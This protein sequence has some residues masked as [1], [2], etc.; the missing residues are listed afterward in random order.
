MHPFKLEFREEQE[1]H[2]SS[3]G[4]RA[5]QVRCDALFTYIFMLVSSALA[6]LG[7]PDAA[8]SRNLSP[9]FPAAYYA[10]QGNK[11]F[12]TLDSYASRASKPN[13][14]T[15]VIRWEWPPWLYLTGH[16]DHWMTMDRLLVLYPTRVLNRDCRSFKVQPFS[17][18]RVTFHYE[19]IDS[20]V[21]IYQEFTFNDYGQITFIEAWTDEPGFLPMNATIDRWAEGK[22]VSRLSTRVP[23]LGRADGR[24]QAIPPQHL[25]R[26]DRD[27]RN[28]QIRLRVPVIAWLVESVRFTFN[29]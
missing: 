25:A 17:R 26:V 13:Y 22:A 6:T 21:D 15:H 9:K 19:W 7:P 4:P 8:F 2:K 27:L 16:K 29:A 1:M 3:S 20:Y 24:Y 5:D 28:L 23:G 18:C 12:D 10:E 11:Y 14:S